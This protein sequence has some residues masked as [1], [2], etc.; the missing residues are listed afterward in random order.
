MEASQALNFAVAA[1]AFK[2]PIPGAVNLVLLA[3]VEQLMGENSS[4]QVQH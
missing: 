2:H 3:E 4:G 1:S